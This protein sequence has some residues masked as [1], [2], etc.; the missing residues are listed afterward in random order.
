MNTEYNTITKQTSRELNFDI[1]NKLIC[2]D[3]AFELSQR[4]LIMMYSYLY[5]FIEQNLTDNLYTFLNTTIYFN[6]IIFLKYLSFFRKL[7][8]LEKKYEEE[9]AKI[10]EES[11]T[12][13]KSLKKYETEKATIDEENKA[14]IEENFK[15]Q[16]NII[17]ENRKYF[18]E[19]IKLIEEENKTIDNFKK[20]FISN[21]I[22]LLINH[23]YI[24]S[25][26]LVTLLTTDT[27]S[28][29]L[30]LQGMEDII[31][32]LFDT[33]I[34]D[35]IYDAVITNINNNPNSF[36]EYRTLF[37]LNPPINNNSVSSAKAIIYIGFHGTLFTV[38]PNNTYLTIK[39]PIDTTINRW[40]TR[41]EPTMF[42][43]SMKY[44]FKQCLLMLDEEKL[45]NF[46]ANSCFE[47]LGTSMQNFNYGTSQTTPACVQE[48]DNYFSD[49]TDF[50]QNKKMRIKH[51][52][53]DSYNFMIFDTD[54][55]IPDT[56]S[57]FTNL[58]KKIPI[59]D[60][61]KQYNTA[62][63]IIDLN[64]LLFTNNIEFN[65]FNML[66]I[67][68]DTRF[69]F[70]KSGLYPDIGLYTKYYFQQDN[71]SLQSHF[72][73]FY[74][75][76][77]IVSFKKGLFIEDFVL[78]R[79]IFT[80]NDI[81]IRL[82]YQYNGQTID[83]SFML[84]K[85]DS[86][87]SNPYIIEYFIRTYNSKITIRPGPI[88]GNKADT[89]FEDNRNEGTTREK[90]STITCLTKGL[91]CY[92]VTLAVLTNYEILKF[93][94]DANIQTC[95]LYDTS[96]QSFMYVND[97]GQIQRNYRPTQQQIQT[98]QRMNTKDDIKI[99]AKYD[100]LS[101]ILFGRLI[102]NP[103]FLVLGVDEKKRK[104]ETI[105]GGKTKKRINNK[106][107]SRKQRK[108]SRKQRKNSRKQRKNS[109]KQRKNSYKQRKN[110]NRI[111]L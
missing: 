57:L 9:K 18:T 39:T 62:E 47:L 76:L 31:K 95:D 65:V 29:E 103:N 96:C 105:D 32:T 38:V 104:N 46:T 69:N 28:I 56:L 36:Q 108:N 23:D 78:E 55:T 11:A 68:D 50:K 97:R 26:D 83:R 90:G 17:L 37:H 109:C 45:N 87:S 93:C 30:I 67:Q 81:N 71:I 40:G 72:H 25:S 10:E 99:L 74:F 12:F 54:Y 73:N 34:I 107:N 91:S 80:L 64:F 60:K 98:L 1:F 20:H 14:R 85:G 41:G 44:T 48:P 2:D 5:L 24:Y 79:D 52:S 61:T 19:A 84:F 15:T 82:T 106:K 77:D 102:K 42:F 66:N 43:N 21:T 16:K 110:T 51:Y 8:A 58:L 13:E 7:N 86:F 53:T 101:D 92:K 111:T 89:I 35:N 4:N 88:L 63:N 75:P 94:K 22:M 70:D 59:L 3:N 33:N 49:L 27:E 100:N 6:K